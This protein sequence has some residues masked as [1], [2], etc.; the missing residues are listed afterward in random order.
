MKQYSVKN[1]VLILMLILLGMVLFVLLYCNYFAIRELDRKTAEA[2]SNALYIQCQNMEKTM[3]SIVVAMV[4]ITA[5]QVPFRQLAYGLSGEYDNYINAFNT[6]EGI[7]EMMYPY[8]D[9]CCSV[10]ISLPK[11]INRLVVN[12]GYN[13]GTTGRMLREALWEIAEDEEKWPG[14]MWIP[15]KVG[16]RFFLVRMMEY[17]STFLFAAI[18]LDEVVLVQNNDNANQAL[19]FFFDETQVYTNFADTEKFRLTSENDKDY[20]FVGR[21]KDKYMVIESELK[22]SSLNVAYLTPKNSIWKN[23][24]AGH[25]FLVFLSLCMLLTLPLGYFLLKR[26][27][28]L[29]LDRLVKE[30]EE[31]TVQKELPQNLEPFREREFIRVDETMH[32]MVNEISR[33]KIEKYEKELQITQVQLEYY[34]V[35]IRPHFYINC[36]KSIYGMLETHQYQDTQKLIVCLSHH[37]R[38]MLREHRNL[39]PL[40]EEL[41]YIENYIELQKISMQYPPECRILCE[42]NMEDYLIP[43]VSLLSFVENSVKYSIPGEDMLRIQVSAGRLRTE[44]ET[45]VR[46]SVSDNGQGFDRETLVKLNSLDGVLAQEGHIGILNVVKRFQLEYGEQVYF[47][48]SNYEGAMSEIFLSERKE[49]KNESVNCG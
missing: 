46:F 39:V 8:S 3:D 27:F 32:E 42:P 34:R 5:E 33:L 23:I 4:N 10:L 13:L 7:A 14:N 43:A 45:L 31:M 36:L 41:R 29:P 6:Q 37:L 19:T 28:F 47:T 26:M 24:G 38:Y 21:G 25:S 35:Q 17:R 48:F 30:M 16:E 15:L 12:R 18:L 40:R 9:W 49:P 22:G 20:Y 2:S 1:R 11:D 44:D